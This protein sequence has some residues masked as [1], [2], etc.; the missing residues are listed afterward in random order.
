M[1]PH[2]AAVRRVHDTTPTAATAQ[3]LQ[4]L[5][6]SGDW[7]LLPGPH[8]VAGASW[9]TPAPFLVI[10]GDLHAEGNLVVATGRH[11]H[12][13]L[14]VLGD[15]HCRN[16]ITGHDQHLVVTGDLV[17]SEAVVAALADSSTVL[18]GSVRADTVISGAGAWLTLAT[19][20]AFQ[21]A[22]CDNYV[23]VGQTP[24]TPAVP[25][26]LTGLL[27][28]AVLDR[29]DWDAMDADEREGEEIGDYVL[30]DESAAL[31][32]LADGGSILRR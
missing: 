31:V 15:L 7:Q 2:L 4:L 19:A 23:M 21:A 9:R 12:G 14:I 28:D 13:V 24:L 26:P 29:D 1:N 5:G 6:M 17:A 8:C 25:S 27:V 30:L 10:D 32:R 22:R 3:A 16:L 20:D 11:D 18:G